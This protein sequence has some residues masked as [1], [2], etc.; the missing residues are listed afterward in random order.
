MHEGDRGLGEGREDER[1]ERNAAGFQA[2]LYYSSRGQRAVAAAAPAAAIDAR[3]AADVASFLLH[4]L[5]LY[6]GALWG[7]CTCMSQAISVGEVTGDAHLAVVRG[8]R[9]VFFDLKCSLQLK[10][11]CSAAGSLSLPGGDTATNA[12]KEGL[13]SYESEG[14]TERHILPAAA[15]AAAASASI[16]AAPACACCCCMG[17]TEGDPQGGGQSRSGR[18]HCSRQMGLVN[19]VSPF[20]VSL[21]FVLGTLNLPE[22]SSADGSGMSW[23]EGSS[24]SLTT[25]PSPLFKPS[26]TDVSV[27][28]CPSYL[29][30]AS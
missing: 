21:F 27:P 23:L 15:A 4:A 2:M 20:T 25:P 16:G 8:T 14:E 7:A 26:E 9:R 24:L 12:L 19:V 17:G 1:R 28:L 5:L 29:P 11:K 30:V 13:G 3:D 22:V 18:R 10:V 6:D